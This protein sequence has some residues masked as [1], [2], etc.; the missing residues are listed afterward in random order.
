MPATFVASVDESGDEG[1]QFGK[2]SSWFVLAG[3]V[4]RQADELSQIKL[5]DEVRA[6]LNQDRKCE[7]CALC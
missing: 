7:R 5:V 3:I 2:G 1:F 6:R 4:L